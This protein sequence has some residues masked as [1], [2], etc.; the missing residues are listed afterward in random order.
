[1]RE[2]QLRLAAISV[3]IFIFAIFL[4]FNILVCADYLQAHFDIADNTRKDG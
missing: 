1:M 2:T 4:S 3:G